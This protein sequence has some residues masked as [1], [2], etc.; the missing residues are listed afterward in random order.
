MG[1]TAD[2]E[3]GAIVLDDR[4]NHDVTELGVASV[5]EGAD[6]HRKAGITS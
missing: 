4:V 2:E 3:E 1:G 5:L 6:H